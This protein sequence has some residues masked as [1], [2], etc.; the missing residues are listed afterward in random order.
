[1]ESPLI[2]FSGLSFMFYGSLILL[3]DHMKREFRRYNM[4]RFRTLTGVLE[5]LGGVGLIVGLSYA[6]V[7]RLSSVGLATLMLMG[8]IVRIKVKDRPVEILPAF[9]LLVINAVIFLK[10]L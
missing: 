7:L 3:S 1:M 6:P 10:S 4:A 5:L 2:W 8:T 9:V